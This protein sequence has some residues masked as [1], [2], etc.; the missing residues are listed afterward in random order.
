MVYELVRLVVKPGFLH[1]TPPGSEECPRHEAAIVV[2]L[3]VV[4]CLDALRKL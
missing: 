4:P 3:L 1:S 2:D